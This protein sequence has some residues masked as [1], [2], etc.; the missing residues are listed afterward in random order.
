MD[1]RYNYRHRKVIG[2]IDKEGDR[3]TEPGFPYLSQYPDNDSN[4]SIFPVL[5]PHAIGRYFSA[6]NAIENNDMIRKSD[7]ALDKYW[8]TQSGYYRLATTVSLGMGNTD[9]EL[10]LWHG[11]SDQNNDKKSSIR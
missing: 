2:F 8:V 3:S 9:T 7:L 1:N 5:C 6:W 4:V 11:I 10:L